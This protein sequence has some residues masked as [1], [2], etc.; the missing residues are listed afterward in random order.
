[1]I[2]IYKRR[3]N[4]L[5]N[6]THNRW[7]RIIAALLGELIF[8]VGLHLFIDPLNLYSGGSTGLSQLIGR[9]LV[10]GLGLNFGG[11]DIAGVIYFLISVPIMIWGFFALGRGVVARSLLCMVA[12]S[13]FYA[14]TPAPAEPIISD[15]LTSCLV[16]GLFAGFG[17]GLVLTCGSSGGGM[18]IVGLCLSKKSP[19]LTVGRVTMTFNVV[20]FAVCLILFDAEILIYSLIFNFVYATVQD[21]IHK[22]SINVQ[23]LIFTRRTDGS[24]SRFIIEKLGRT[25]TYWDG[26]G[27]YSGE[28]VRV[29][30][31]CLSKYEVEELLRMVNEVD[32]TAFVTVQEGSSIYGRFDR[33]LDA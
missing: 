8:A 7:L 32:P 21:R 13:F 17:N 23:A 11:I 29:L 6:T 5:Y 33:H 3:G 22:Q 30:C 1:M 26:V 2:S 27:A 19:S 28:G 24:V 16:G 18:D 4:M 20:F 10:N 12:F 25:V 15:T 14:V 31:V 9:L